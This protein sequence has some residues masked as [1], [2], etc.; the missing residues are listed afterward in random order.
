LK[1][2][3]LVI[4]GNQFLARRFLRKHSILILSNAAANR[5]VPEF[6]MEF[7]KA[8]WART[9]EFKGT[10]RTRRSAGRSGA[11]AE[12]TMPVPTMIDA[13]RV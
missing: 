3:I 7:V 1:K 8:F 11:F 13:A 4:V 5:S 6:A 2:F 9:D 12:I 10:A